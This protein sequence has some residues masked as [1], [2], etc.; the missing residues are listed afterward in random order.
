LLRLCNGSVGLGQCS[1]C[2]RQR[3]LG[4]RRRGRRRNE[5]DDS[6][7]AQRHSRCSAA[8]PEAAC[9]RPGPEIRHYHDQFF[10]H[11]PALKVVRLA[12]AGKLHVREGQRLFASG[13]RV[14][15]DMVTMLECLC[16]PV[17]VDTDRRIPRHAVASQLHRL[18]VGSVGTQWLHAPFLEVVGDV[19]RGETKT[20]R[21]NLTA[22]QFVGRQ[23]RQPFLQIGLSD[24][25]V[26]HALRGLRPLRRKP[27]R[28]SP[29]KEQ[30]RRDQTDISSG[31]I[32]FHFG[33]RKR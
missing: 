10:F 17:H 32:G 5:S 21:E 2:V 23:I 33:L 4:R 8:C 27:P 30:E 20:F 7:R 25:G 28:L 1:L 18:Q 3:F 13:V 16:F 22:R 26:F 24:L 12:V 29:H 19:L 9:S 15:R 6:F 31:K 11:V 14:K